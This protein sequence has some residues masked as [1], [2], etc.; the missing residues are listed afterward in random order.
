[1]AQAQHVLSLGLSRRLADLLVAEKIISPQQLEEALEAQ[2]R[3]GE[4]L[5][6]VLIGKGF[7]REEQLLEFLSR[8]CG[9]SYVSLANVPIPEEALA[10]VPESLARAH[11]LVPFLKSEDRITVAVA[12][13]LNVLVLDDL[14]M[15]TGC[16][17]RAVLASE[18]EIH[19]AL[20]K[21]YKA[22]SSQ[23]ALAE[24][25]RQSGIPAEE[26]DRI[27][28]IEE[29]P[30]GMADSLALKSL[31][32]EAPVVKMVNLVLASAVKARASDIHLE[33]FAKETRL[34]YR[35]DGVLHEQPAPPRRFHSAISTRI[36]IMS[37]LDIS[38]RRIPQDGRLKLRIEGKLVDMRVSVLP[39]SFGEKIVL[40]IL[41][42]SGLRVQLSQLGFE[43]EALAVFTKCMKAPY[44][45]NLITGPTGSG[46]STTLY[47][48]LSNL[49]TPDTNIMTVEDPVE[50][51]LHGINQVQVNPAVGLTFAAGLRAFLRQDPDV[52]MVGEVR[53]LE[54]AQIAI[55]AALTGHLVF[56][57]LHTNDAPSTLTRLAMMGVEP[58][59]TSSAL[60][61]VLAQRL[62][63]MICPKCRESYEIEPDWLVKLGVPEQLLGVRGGRVALHRGRGCEHCAGTGYR[64]RQG[65][66]EVLEVTEPM[67]QLILEK[68]PVRE[69][70]SL[71]LKQGM[72]TLRECAV[73]KLLGGG[74][75]V[76]EMIRV[77]ASD[78]EG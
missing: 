20:D 68:A 33:P 27:G 70:K 15:M 5:G 22:P 2:R 76:E 65:L 13:P 17:V 14:K 4:K 23:E 69:I 24:I 31:A 73:R 53:D 48:A 39:C 40:R 9:I 3:T 66:Y 16:D 25:V 10:A 56:S 78:I 61:M 18:A 54:T 72:L 1:M 30:E 6:G 67:R 19:A 51:Q 47:S 74:T 77:T 62:V 32:E 35:I 75:T 50:Y 7:L 29:R 42:S 63:R 64:G 44:G 11:L 45:I 59:L 28:L 26:A 55:S 34:R 52:I 58:F 8:M 21:Y 71:A 49:N 12:D 43:P 38:E 36:K 57:T 60:L 37:N 41:D 46:K